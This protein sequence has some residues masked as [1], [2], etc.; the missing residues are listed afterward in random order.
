MKKVGKLLLICVSILLVVEQSSAQEAD[1]LIVLQ[2]ESNLE[3]SL[4]FADSTYIGR[5]SQFTFLVPADTRQIKLVPPE[6]NSWSIEPV[7]SSVSFSGQ[8][9]ASL[10][11]NFPFYYKIESIP[12]NASIYLEKPEERQLLGSTPLL[13]TSEDPL[14]GMLLLSVDGYESFRLTPGEDIWNQH[15]VELKEQAEEDLI[16]KRYW[17]PERSRNRWIDYTAAG[18]SLVGGVLAIRYKTKANR[19]FDSY[20]IS[21]DPA[22]RNGFERY[23]RYAAISLGAMQAGIGVLA[24]RFVIK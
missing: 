17:T 10:S 14:K 4:V 6:Y 9:T 23:D 18:V 20:R 16:S 8:D 11:I 12:F 3:E 21:G 5:S 2:L 22:L 1:S 24:I 19:R 13:Y 15:L 7:I